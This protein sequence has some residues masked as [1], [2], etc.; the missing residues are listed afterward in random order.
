LNANLR[1]LLLAVA[2]LA[3]FPASAG[4]EVNTASRAELEAVSGVGPT[5]AAAIL[6]ERSKGPFK[7]W[8][9]LIAR[10]KGLRHA[11]AVRLSAEGLTVA[12][13]PYS[14]PGS[15]PKTQ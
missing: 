15:E 3:V 14:S 5:L 12:G 13:E 2:M 7:H 9:N 6:D 10:V 8:P 4:V 11:S 1:R